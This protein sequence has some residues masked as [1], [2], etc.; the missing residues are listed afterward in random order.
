M[1]AKKATGFM[2]IM[3]VLLVSPIAAAQSTQS[4]PLQPFAGQVRD[5]EATLS[6]LGQPL[7]S[8]DQKSINTAFGNPDPAAAVSEAEAILDKYTLAA[9]TINAE[10]RVSVKPG[11]AP[12]ELIQNGTRVFLVK[13]VNRAGVTAPLVVESPNSG[14][15]YLKS[16]ADP[17]PAQRLTMED[18]AERWSQIYFYDKPMMFRPPVAA[19]NNRLSGFG[20]EYRL[21][22][23]YSR[24]AGQR[25]AKLSFNVGQG[26]Q[27][28]G[29][30][31]EITILFAIAPAHS[32][33][34]HVFDDIGEPTMASF[35]FR[36]NVGRIYPSQTKRL[37]PDFFFQQQVYRADGEFIDLPEGSY[38]VTVTG[39][40]E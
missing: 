22:V 4:V 25:S 21:L 30:R 23:I 19:G 18:V 5:V 36:D 38:N 11:L 27:D 16:T 33:T 7:A 29:F 20:L 28:I 9:V 15:V 35:I 3:M 17:T 6:F 40:P 13:V 37:A 34:L 1:K 26:T 39:G 24:D 2:A 32:I 10:S 31:S 12:A 14:E 8:G